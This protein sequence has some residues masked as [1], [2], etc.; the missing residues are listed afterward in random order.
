[1]LKA[2]LKE[3]GKYRAQLIAISKTKPADQ[4]MKLYDQGQRNFG[5]NRVLELVEKQGILPKDISWHMVG[6]LQRNKVKYIAPFVGLIHS[7]DS[8]RLF[9]EIEKEGKKNQRKIAVLIQIK[10]AKEESKAGLEPQE[11]EAF[12]QSEAVR[13]ASFVSIKGVMG[14]ASFVGDEHQIRAEFKQ[15]VSHF[16]YIKKTFFPEQAGFKEISMGM[17][18]DYQIAL[19]EGATIVR[20]G[21]L[22]FGSR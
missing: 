2:L 8:L 4:I 10:I 21:S 17:S 20:I 14:M 1:M 7:V 16:L 19:E 15:L 9:R 6:H 11:I 12:F 22:L 13:N 5:E 3:L 18:G